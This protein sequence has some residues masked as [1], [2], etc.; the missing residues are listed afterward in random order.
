MRTK[1]G[2]GK[3]RPTA[4]F[5][6]L[7]RSEA[8]VAESRCF[9]WRNGRSPI[10]GVTCDEERR[11]RLV[12]RSPV[13]VDH[14]FEKEI[15]GVGAGFVVLPQLGFLGTCGRNQSDGGSGAPLFLAGCTIGFYN[16]TNLARL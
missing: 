5:G 8:A 11:H 7:E 16:Y 12:K 10:H 9:K 4:S 1:N 3:H 15:L 13:E 6:E 2:E 14:D